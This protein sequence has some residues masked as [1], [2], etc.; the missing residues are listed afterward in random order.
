MGVADE[1]IRVSKTV[2]RTI[3]RHR[4]EGESYNDVL[5]RLLDEE[6]T[7]DFYLV[8]VEATRAFYEKN[9]GAETRWVVPVPALAEVLVGAGTLPKGDVGGTH[10]NLAWGDVHPI[11]ERTAVTAGHIADTIAPGGPYLDGPDALIA[12]VGREL[13]AP[14]V[15]ADGDFTHEETKQVIDVEEY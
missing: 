10:A 7:G 9:G 14:I 1:Q 11:D 4:R 15:S 12:A 13:D 8:G 3:E 5:E 2:K 6:D